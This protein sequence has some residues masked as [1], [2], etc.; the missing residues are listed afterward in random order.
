MGSMMVNG[1]ILAREHHDETHCSYLEDHL[2][3]LKNGAHKIV[4]KN[5][6]APC[7]YINLSKDQLSLK[8]SYYVGVDWI[9]EGKLPLMVESKINKDREEEIDVLGMLFD[10]MLHPENLAHL[11]GLLHI[12]FDRPWITIPEQ[13]DVLSPFLIVQFMAILSKIVR[14]GIRKDYYRVTN[15]L[16]N[17]VKGKILVAEQIKQN[18]FKNRN[19][20]TV[21]NYQEFGTDHPENQ[22]L[23]LVLWQIQRYLEENPRLFSGFSNQL[24]QS[25][26]YCLPAFEHVQIAQQHVKTVGV[27]RSSFYTEY[28]KAVELGE[29]ILR[30]LAFNVTKKFSSTSVQTPPF[31]IDMSKLFELYVFGKLKELFPNPES[32]SYHDSFAGGKETD[33]SL[34]E[35]DYKCVIDCKYKPK[36][37]NQNPSLEDKRQQPG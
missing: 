5:T 12:E 17:R 4:F 14:K 27:K 32:L 23:K 37:E 15:N 6:N 22:F 16:R 21:C 2:E 11:D 10:S 28:L 34:K 33:I 13:Q 29:A 19:T 8:T 18:V 3:D 30:R 36:Y 9:I 25:I 31:W 7:Y 26:I 35:I 24:A 1:L 20:N